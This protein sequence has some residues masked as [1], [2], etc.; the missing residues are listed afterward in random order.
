MKKTILAFSLSLL[1]STAALG[2]LANEFSVSGVRDMNTDKN[3]VRVVASTNSVIGF[4][5]HLTATYIKDAYGRYGVGTD[6]KLLDIG[7]LTL[8][9]SGDVVYQ[10][11]VV[12]DSGYG[13]VGGAKVSYA[14]TPT[15]GVVAGFERF[16]GQD[17]VSSSDGNVASLGLKA[18]F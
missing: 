13:A 7:A 2:V 15:F 17:K 18:R 12:G 4:T 6:F 3:G 14:I 16:F 9:A 8:A 5:P 1:L 11:S 10:N